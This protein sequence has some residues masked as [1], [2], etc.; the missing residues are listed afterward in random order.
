MWKYRWLGNSPIINWLLRQDFSTDTRPDALASSDSV[1]QMQWGAYEHARTNSGE[2]G[3]R[4]KLGGR[5]ESKD[6]RKVPFSPNYGKLCS[7]P[8]LTYRP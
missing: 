1:C 4:A 5:Y 7:R 2:A 8:Y 3:I 6:G